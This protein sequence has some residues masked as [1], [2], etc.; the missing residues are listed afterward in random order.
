MEPQDR[1]RQIMIWY[2]IA[3]VIGVLVALMVGTVFVYQVISSDITQR[4]AEYATLK[5]MGYGS[6]YLASVV[7][8]Q[9]VLYGVLGYVPGFALTLVLYEWGSAATTLPITMDWQRA[10][11]VLMLSVL[12]CVVSG[13][14][15]VKKVRTAD[16]ADLF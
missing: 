5:A 12:M 14:F 16:P 9:A 2:T 4:F 11:I 1:K 8:Q 7:L 10:L 6:G 15:A 13:F 3:A